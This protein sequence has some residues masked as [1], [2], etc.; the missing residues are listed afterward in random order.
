VITADTNLF[1]YAVDARFPEKQQIAV[2]LVSTLRDRGARVA[3][4]VVGEFQNALCRRLKVPL[5]L[6]SE[7]ASIVLESF[8]TFAASRSAA[9]VAL[10][11][12]AAGRLSYWDA[13]MVA[14]AA[15]AGCTAMLSED[16][17]D[18][19][20]I[21]GVEIINPFGATGVS[22]RAAELLQLA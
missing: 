9:R 7:R 15:E 11:E 3:L 19:R 10:V 12:M 8:A 2:R 6:S 20:T 14:S 21:F 1:V 16:M 13:L 4:Q 18:G 22:P 17:Q 5:P